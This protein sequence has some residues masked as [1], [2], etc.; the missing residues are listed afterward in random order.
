MINLRNL[1]DQSRV[2]EQ[3]SLIASRKPLE[4]SPPSKRFEV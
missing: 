4:R 3:H 2:Q 1:L